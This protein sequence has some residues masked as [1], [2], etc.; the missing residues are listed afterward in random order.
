DAVQQSLSAWRDIFNEAHEQ[1]ESY[2]ELPYVEAGCGFA[3]DQ[4]KETEVMLVKK[5]RL[6]AADSDPVEQ[7]LVTVVCSSPLSISGGFGMSRIAERE[8][9]FVPSTKSVTE[10]GQTTTKV[11][12]R[13]GFKNNSSFRMIPLL[14][15]NTRIKEWNDTV[16]LHMSA[17]AG[18]D[19]K[20][21]EAGTDVEFVAGPTLSF[22]RTMFV[23][24]GVHFGR[25]PKL[26]GGFE[27]GQEV[28]EGIDQPPI[29]KAWK[30]GFVIAVTYKLK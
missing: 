7:S 28:P 25:V 13:F 17:G 12:N 24:A 20:T 19:I 9:V 29:E 11:I 3:F 16:A 22:K 26:A 10:N 14:L 8:F 2:F 4:N 1:G 5:D 6:A 23:T 15:L 21:G 27:V 30:P 18:V